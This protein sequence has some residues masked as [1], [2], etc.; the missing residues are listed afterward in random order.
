MEGVRRGTLGRVLGIA[1]A[2]LFLYH[3]YSQIIG[4]VNSVKSFGSHKVAYNDLLRC[5]I[6]AK[7]EW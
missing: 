5:I 7:E 3:N 4:S 2:A 1:H 6:M